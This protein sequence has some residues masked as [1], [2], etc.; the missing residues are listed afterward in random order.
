[1]SA[2]EKV[3]SLYADY[4][5]IDS[6]I[7][8]MSWDQQV[9]M[10]PG[11]AAA[12]SAQVGQLTAMAHAIITGD[13]LRTALEGAHREV[14]PDSDDGAMLRNLQ[15]EVDIETKLPPELVLRKAKIAAESYQTWRSA[16]PANDFARMAPYYKELFE[17]AKETADLLGYKD[18]PYDAL[19]DLYEQGA[20]HQLAQSMFDRIKGPIVDLVRE[21][22]ENG[23][24]VDDALLFNEWDQPKL[25]DFAQE[26]ATQIGYDFG[27][28]RLDIS[29]SAFCSSLSSGDVRMTTRA[30]EHIKGILSS[31][32]HEMG[33]GLYEQGSPKKWDLTPLAGGAS[34]AVHESQSRLWENI[35]GR[36]KPFWTHFFPRLTA[37]FPNLSSMGTEG[38]YRAFSKVNPTFVRVGSDELTYNLHILIRFEI[39]V[40][41]LTGQIEAKDL[42][43]V[44]NSKYT[45]YMGITPPTDTLGVLQDVHWTRGSAGYFPTYSMGNLIGGQIWSS[46][47]TDLGNTDDKMASGDFSPVLAW[48][49]EKV[50]SKAK[51]CE[52]GDLVQRV[53]G[54][55]MRADEWLDY[56]Y[57]KYREIYAL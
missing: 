3:R 51:R 17:I 12:R 7:R 8:I 11:G 44:W 55:A 43:E 57:A 20:T 25:R 49:Q 41:M 52:P 26:M 4:N 56:A 39:E 2:L 18:H 50:Y 15:R 24:P 28:G 31:S 23:R 48:L 22:R 6:G 16:K 47:Q 10:P 14:D 1:M 19:I 36:S 53:T 37:R 46:L 45:E 35:I 27:R 54:H 29:A 21:I 32:L 38:F 13:A 34:L 30:S 42:P 33:H 40:L 9:L 5:A